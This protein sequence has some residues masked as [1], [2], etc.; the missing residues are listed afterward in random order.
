MNASATS[1][2]VALERERIAPLTWPM[3][4]LILCVRDPAAPSFPKL[5]LLLTVAMATMPL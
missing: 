3:E 2:L 5:P 4:S 1:C